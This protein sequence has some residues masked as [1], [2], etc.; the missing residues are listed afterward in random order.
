MEETTSPS[1]LSVKPGSLHTTKILL[2]FLSMIL[3]LSL[4]HNH[5]ILI[6]GC[7]LI[8][9][10]AISSQDN[11]FEYKAGIEAGFMVIMFCTSAQLLLTISDILQILIT[12]SNSLCLR[13]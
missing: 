11:Y 3:K 2:I 8:D 12:Y 6:L 9:L 4:G 7:I 1:T 5:A 13:L 10:R